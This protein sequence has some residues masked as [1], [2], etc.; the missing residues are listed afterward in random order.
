MD[1]ALA[2]VREQ[3]RRR[4]GDDLQSLRAAMQAPQGLGTVS[5]QTMVHRISGISGSL[6]FPKLGAVAA[7]ID[8]TCSRGAGVDPTGLQELE[9]ALA[10]VVSPYGDAPAR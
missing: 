7:E 3:F 1:D 9:I 8:R 5:F 6:G 4:C 10:E 2:Q